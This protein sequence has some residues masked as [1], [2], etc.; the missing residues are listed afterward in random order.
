M[1]LKTRR[2]VRSTLAAEMLSLLEGLDAAFYYRQMLQEFLGLDIKTINIEAYVDNKS[3]VEAISSTRMVEDKR[4][5]V[6]IATIQESLKFQDVSRIHWVAVH[7]QLA[8]VMTKQLSSGFHL[9]NELQ[10]GQ[11]L[12]EMIR[13]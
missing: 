4:L 10:S 12:S 3:G 7:L 6:D 9:L 1:E 5:C 13:Q 8:N 11:M 2:V